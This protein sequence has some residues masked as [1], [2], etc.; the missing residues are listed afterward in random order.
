MEFFFPPTITGG[1]I[2]KRQIIYVWD[3]SVS[4]D[5]I[6]SWDVNYTVLS[7]HVKRQII[8]EGK[9]CATLYLC[10]Q[11][12][13]LDDCPSS[14]CAFYSSS[15]FSPFLSRVYLLSGHITLSGLI[16]FFCKDIV[17]SHYCS[18]CEWKITHLSLHSLPQLYKARWRSHTQ[19][20]CLTNTYFSSLNHL[21]RALLLAWFEIQRLLMTNQKCETDN[22]PLWLKFVHQ[23]MN[24]V[25]LNSIYKKSCSSLDVI[26]FRKWSF[27]YCVSRWSSVSICHSGY[28]C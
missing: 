21:S 15:F 2:G 22:L 12:E 8:E 16:I 3:W 5:P 24:S 20:L 14:L 6:I 13:L 26:L 18:L 1:W 28:R 9:R 19:L 7:L 17:W 23:E 11:L 10:F 4:S 25:Q 27:I